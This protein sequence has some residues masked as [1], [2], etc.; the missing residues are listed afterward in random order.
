MSESPSQCFHTDGGKTIPVRYMNQ[1]TI[2]TGLTANF[3]VLFPRLDDVSLETVG[4]QSPLL[5]GHPIRGR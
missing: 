5:Y 4:F 2:V 1:L 3:A